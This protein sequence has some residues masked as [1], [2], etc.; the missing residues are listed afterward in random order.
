VCNAA[1]KTQR[2]LKVDHASLC[3]SQLD[4][5]QNA[6]AKVGL[7]AEYGGPHASGGTHMALLG[8]EDG[9]YL[10]LIAPL[11]PGGADDSPWGEMIATNAGACAWAVGTTDIRAEASRLKQ[12]G[13]PIAG[14]F[15]GS[16][17]RPDG[18][19]IEWQTAHVGPGGPGS[20]MPFMIQDKT[21]RALRVQPSPSVRGL[22]LRGISKVV[23]AV[24]DLDSSIAM[25]REAYDWPQPA[26]EP[27]DDWNARVAYFPG[28]PVMLATPRD[29][30][31][32]LAKR[33]QLYG[34]A[35]AAFLL[36]AEDPTTASMVTGGTWFGKD[37]HWFDP[38]KLQGIRL[39][40]IEK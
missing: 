31:G 10:E 35:P 29:D 23:I 36:S 33:V 38:D 13:I 18:Q 6:F 26:I 11:K 40:V 7:T 15:P 4:L 19:L 1:D 37:V 30:T 32:W 8:F 20:L 5:L 9:S 39:G 2:T 24:R 34:N 14:P 27:R 22:G 12:L 3:T 17:K 21:A 25:F 16:R 28:T